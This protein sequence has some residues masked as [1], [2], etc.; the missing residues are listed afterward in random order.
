MISPIEITRKK[1]EMRNNLKVVIPARYNS[2]RFPGKVLT[3]INGKTM[4]HH[5]Y[6]RVCESS[7]KEVI[8]ATDDGRVRDHAVMIGADVEMTF[9]H[10]ATG[11]DRIMEVARIRKWEPN[12]FI[13]NV[14]GDS[15]LISPHSIDQVA[16]MLFMYDA[17]MATLATKI[18]DEQELYNRN[19][20]KVVWDNQGN[21][22]YFSR[23]PIPDQS[24]NHYERPWAW[25][26]LG[27]YGYMLSGLEKITSTGPSQLESI[28][29][30]EQLR[31]LGMGINIKVGVASN[32]H[33]TDVDVPED[34]DKVE[35]IMTY[36]ASER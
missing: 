18:T 35:N 9:G 14:Q 31:A 21:A 10:H 30:L 8:I 24:G 34:V 33:G 29:K 36:G 19:I 32:P 3:D 23:S 7:A 17:P 11:T 6:E 27:I 25:R 2:S 22:L 1:Q 28:E 4:L 15:P 16:D 26:H 13:V 20:V 5:V 12:T